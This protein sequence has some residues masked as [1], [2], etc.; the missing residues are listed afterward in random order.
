M[1]FLYLLSDICEFIAFI[2][3]IP[4]VIFKSLAIYLYNATTGGG[5]DPTQE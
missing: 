4:S 2:L 5:E 3:A 1:G